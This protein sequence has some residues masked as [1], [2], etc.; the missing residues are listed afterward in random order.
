[1]PAEPF[2][3]LAYALLLAVSMKLIFDGLRP[4]I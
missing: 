2:Y 1:M 3:R 4:L